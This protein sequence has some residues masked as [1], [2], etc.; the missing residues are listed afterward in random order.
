M[1]YEEF[2]GESIG[3]KVFLKRKTNSEYTI[4]GTLEGID[5][6]LKKLFV[7]SEKDDYMVDFSDILSLDIKS[8]S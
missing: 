6:E 3:K 8:H 7:I 5:L 1:D 4:V 2:L